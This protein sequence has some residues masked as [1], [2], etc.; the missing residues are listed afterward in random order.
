M[1]TLQ[2]TAFLCMECANKGLTTRFICGSRGID[3]LRERAID[4]LQETG[5]HMF[6]PLNP[7]PGTFYVIAGTTTK[8]GPVY[9]EGANEEA[10]TKEIIEEARSNQLDVEPSWELSNDSSED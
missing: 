8:V 3:A 5:H 6:R 2:G 7:K 10:W 4:H 1:K 9:K